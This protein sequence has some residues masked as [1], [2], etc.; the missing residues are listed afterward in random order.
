MPTIVLRVHAWHDAAA[1]GRALAERHKK[2]QE[3]KQI[4]EFLKTQWEDEI[5]FEDRLWVLGLSFS[6]QQDIHSALE[7]LECGS[8]GEHV[9]TTHPCARAT[10]RGRDPL[11]LLERH[12]GP[13]AVWAMICPGGL[14]EVQQQQERLVATHHGHGDQ[15]LVD[16]LGHIG[17]R[18]TRN[19]YLLS[20]NLSGGHQRCAR[21][22][23]LD[24]L[25]MLICDLPSSKLPVCIR[26]SSNTPL[27]L[28]VQNA[29]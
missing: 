27:L 1:V 11:D 17:K 22:S 18:P 29:M 9:Y 7:H 3:D 19:F 10:S 16:S 13:P 23:V 6:K 15:L 28:S 14:S 2:L 4:P 26:R 20:M 12:I 8:P 5:S 21:H 24:G 25:Q